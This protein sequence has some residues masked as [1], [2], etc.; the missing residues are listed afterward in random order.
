VQL[1]EP[2]ADP[3]AVGLGGGVVRVGREVFEFEDL[4]GLRGLDPGDPGLERVLLRLAVGGGLGVGGGSWAASSAAR[5]GPNTRVAKNPP[6]TLSRR[7]SA[8]W[9]VR[10]WSG[11]SAAC[12]GLAQLCGHR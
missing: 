11:W 4:G 1:G 5:P 8:A 2:G 3:G 7:V 6:T 9:T 12:L 10:G